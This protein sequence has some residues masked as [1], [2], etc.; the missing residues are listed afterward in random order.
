[1]D[2]VVARVGVSASYK[3]QFAEAFGSSTVTDARVLKAL[4]AFMSRL[5]SA[6]SPY[7]RYLVTGQGLSAAALK[8]LG[9]FRQHCT[10]CHSEPLTSNGGFHSNAWPSNLDVGRYRITEN[11]Q[12]S[13]KFKVPSL[14]NVARTYPYMHDGTAKTL[15]QVVSHY[16]SLN[17]SSGTEESNLP[18]QMDLSHE[19][20]R[21]LISFLESLTDEHFLSN[22]LFAP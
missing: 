21:N 16:N 7:D 18:V 12:D 3:K 9:I 4:S 13:G 15:E 20:Q 19:E 11:S 1:M 8:G 2:E 22:P 6:D 10:G 5:I 17:A 14:R